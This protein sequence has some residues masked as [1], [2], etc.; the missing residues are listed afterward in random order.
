M[1]GAILLA[2]LTLAAIA[3]ARWRGFRFGRVALDMVG[4]IGGAAVGA[5]PVGC[6]AIGPFITISVEGGA[7]LV[8]PLVVLAVGG[9]A[10][11]LGG[12]LAADRL[13]ALQK[14]P[15]KA[16]ATALTGLA[17]A[18]AACYLALLLG[19]QTAAELAVLLLMPPCGAAAMVAG[20]SVPAAHV[21]SSFH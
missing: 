4:A 21:G 14:Q 1:F 11:G 5:V 17:V 8:T 7:D 2:G 6:L 18:V 16:W 9:A 19:Q 10:G 12:L 13:V 3:V 15:R 20:Y